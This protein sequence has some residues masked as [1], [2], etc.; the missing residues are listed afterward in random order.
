MNRLLAVAGVFVLYLGLASA[1]A[2][3]PQGR[4]EDTHGREATPDYARVFA[5]D[6]VKRLDIV[7]TAA[8]WDRL[9]AD[10]TEMAGPYGGAEARGGFNVMPDPAAVAACD[11]RVEGDV[12][13]F[14][15]PPQSGR[16][17]LL[18]M[19]AGLTCT[20]LPGGGFPG[21]NLPGGGGNPPGGGGILPEAAI[22]RAATWGATMWSSCRGRPSTFRRR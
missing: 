10:M 14:G 13:T 21:G 17:T 2:G 4:D 15:T 22:S 5:Q 6:V 16:C 11:G 7:V 12:C 19:G 20:A 9:V 8:D 1:G 18:P 3:D